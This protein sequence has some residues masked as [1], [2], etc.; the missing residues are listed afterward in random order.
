MVGKEF[1]F[2]PLFFVC[3][4]RIVVVPVFQEK[5]YSNS[6]YMVTFIQDYL[7][8]GLATGERDEAQL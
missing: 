1:S 4:M 5:G 8:K 2:E 6:C 3:Y 7:K